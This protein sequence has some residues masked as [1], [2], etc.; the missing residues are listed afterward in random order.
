[1]SPL[2]AQTDQAR[3]K[4]DELRLLVN[5]RHPIIAIETAEEGRVEELLAEVAAELG[6]PL[7]LWSVTTGLARKGAE[8]PIYH[9][10]NPEQALASVA[11]ISGDARSEERRVGKEW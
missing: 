11:L 2:L 5:S 1:M 3:D 9:T 8:A 4:K 7:F 6:V 10:D